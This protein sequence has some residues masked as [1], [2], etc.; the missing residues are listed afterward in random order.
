MNC[1]PIYGRGP[2]PVGPLEGLGHPPPTHPLDCFAVSL[3]INKIEWLDEAIAGLKKWSHEVGLKRAF[4]LT[5]RDIAGK[6][7][8][9]LRER[10][11][12]F[13][14]ITPGIEASSCIETLNDVG[15]WE[16]LAES[17]LE[18]SKII[19]TD[20]VYMDFEGASKLHLPKQGG[21]KPEIEPDWK[22][23]HRGLQWLPPLLTYCWYP[24]VTSERADI[25]SFQ[26]RFLHHALAILPKVRMIDLSISSPGAMRAWTRFTKAN[27]QHLERMKETF[28]LPEMIRM[29]YFYGDGA[30]YWD[31]WHFP[32]V[33]NLVPPWQDILIYT[34]WSRWPAEGLLK[35]VKAAQ[36]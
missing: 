8:S 2:I 17:L 5:Q 32:L 10:T 6:V 31:D 28:T 16:L 9:E 21:E 14:R 22:L 20:T 15:G 3:E 19:G 26:E 35:A 18:A 12:H 4:I 29:L 25:R 27:H 13:L 23:I 24:T 11:S 33:K 30:G 36:E 34:G 1:Q 7:L